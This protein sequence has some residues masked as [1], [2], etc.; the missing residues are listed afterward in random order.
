MPA[1]ALS[2]KQMQSQFFE[3]LNLNMFYSKD[4]SDITENGILE[5]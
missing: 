1:C 5:K 4:N 2:W 3:K